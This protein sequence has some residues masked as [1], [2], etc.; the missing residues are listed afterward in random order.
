MLP[1]PPAGELKLRVAS[2][3]GETVTKL[4]VVSTLNNVVALEFWIWKPLTE[5]VAFA[6]VAAPPSAIVTTAV[7]LSLN[8]ATLPVLVELLTFKASPDVRPVMVVVPVRPIVLALCMVIAP[9]A[10][11]PMA[12]APVEV[13]V[14]MFVAKLLDALILVTAPLIVAP[15]WPVNRLLIVV[16]L[17]ATL[18]SAVPKPAPL[19]A[20]TLNSDV[21][22]AEL[23][24]WMS[25]P[26]RV[27]SSLIS[28]VVPPVEL[29]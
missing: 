15:N 25:R 12:T 5:L 7:E 28:G 26:P 9:A 1:I 14:L 17:L 3:S 13:P 10:L 18:R 16:P 11:L 27:L 23:A 4:L 29:L 21:P 6:N 24:S 8:T 22:S 20:R 19:L 2:S